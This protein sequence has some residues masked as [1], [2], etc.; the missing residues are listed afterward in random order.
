MLCVGYADYPR[1]LSCWEQ[2]KKR[3]INIMKL[4]SIKP[5]RTCSQVM[6]GLSNRWRSSKLR[7]IIHS[8]MIMPFGNSA[9]HSISKINHLSK[10][11]WTWSKTL[12]KIKRLRCISRSGSFSRQIIFLW[13]T[14]LVIIISLSKMAVMRCSSDSIKMK[15]KWLPTSWQNTLK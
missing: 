2:K 15:S 1:Y 8:S 14:V 11:Q 7:R 5:F 6:S 3:R 9:W 13:T 4:C 12:S 10:S